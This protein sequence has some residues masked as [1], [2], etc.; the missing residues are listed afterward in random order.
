[1]SLWGEYCHRKQF[2][3]M[4]G[5][6]RTLKHYYKTGVC[7]GCGKEPR[8][9]RIDVFRL[10]QPCGACVLSEL[11]ARLCDTRHEKCLGCW[12]K[13]QLDL[14]NRKCPLCEEKIP[15]DRPWWRIV[16]RVVPEKTNRVRRPLARTKGP[17]RI[18]TQGREPRSRGEAD[19]I[20][21]IERWCSNESKLRRKRPNARA[22]GEL[23]RRQPKR[24]AIV[25]PR[26]CCSGTDE[27]IRVPAFKTTQSRWFR[28][29][30]KR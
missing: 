29:Q 30:G 15:A 28:S 8:A 11:R 20:L 14:S 17:S 6:G 4:L 2:P 25:A 24:S 21:G 16:L 3:A 26:N 12:R 19:S 9:K 13:E 5:S 10:F 7:V 22:R 23:R 18:P 27:E 1:M